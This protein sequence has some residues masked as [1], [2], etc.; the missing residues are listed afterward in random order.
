MN[1]RLCAC[2]SAC[3]KS[4]FTSQIWSH[5]TSSLK[6][7]EVKTWFAPVFFSFCPPNSRLHKT[8]RA[9]WHVQSCHHSHICHIK[10][11]LF[12]W[13]SCSVTCTL[14]WSEIPTSYNLM[15]SAF[16]W[17]NLGNKEVLSQNLLIQITWRVGGGH[18]MYSLSHL[19]SQVR[20]C[21]CSLA[22]GMN[23]Q[24]LR[25]TLFFLFPCTCLVKVR[26]SYP[27]LLWNTQLTCHLSNQP[28]SFLTLVISFNFIHS[29]LQ[30]V[31]G[32]PS[33][34]PSSSVYYGC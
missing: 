14:Y 4:C 28:E 11:E 26:Q 10:F 34:F 3:V 25:E 19:Y 8:W 21:N 29:A 20:E 7:W 23:S 33:L 13:Y 16:T 1:F 31:N 17:P 6:M 15:A 27:D 5:R 2:T 12:G 24:R 9:K 30:T 32:Q 22:S 18:A